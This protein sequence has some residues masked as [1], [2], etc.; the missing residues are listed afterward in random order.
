MSRVKKPGNKYMNTTKY[1][2]SVTGTS[3]MV[4]IHCDGEDYHKAQTLSHWLFTKYDMSYKTY[5][6]KTKKRR[7]LK[8]LNNLDFG[9]NWDSEHENAMEQLAEMGVS[10]APDGTP[11]GSGLDD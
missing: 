2:S 1:D 6:K 7:T 9:S 4:R 10:F 8:R 5:R 3:K 11:I